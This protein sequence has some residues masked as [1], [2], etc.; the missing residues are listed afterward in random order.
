MK[1]YRVGRKSR[2]SLLQLKRSLPRRAT[3]YSQMADLGQ[4]P[5]TAPPSHPADPDWPDR[6]D[7]KGF[8]IVFDRFCLLFPKTLEK[9]SKSYK[10]IQNLFFSM[11]FQCFSSLFVTF[12]MF[13]LC[14]RF[15]YKIYLAFLTFFR[16]VNKINQKRC[17][18]F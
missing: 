2:H 13:V 16:K 4:T 5:A 6:L 14:F 11:L 1:R 8:Y 7:F 17:K 12:P 9:L 18:I 10:N 15:V 3:F